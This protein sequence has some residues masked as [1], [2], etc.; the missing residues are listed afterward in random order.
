M[1]EFGGSPSQLVPDNGGDAEQPWGQLV[2]GFG[3]SPEGL[4]WSEGLTGIGIP[5]IAVRYAESVV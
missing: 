3:P 5:V 2:G 1:R 4:A